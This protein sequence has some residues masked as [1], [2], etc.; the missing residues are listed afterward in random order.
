VKDFSEDVGELRGFLGGIRADGGGDGPEDWVGGARLVLRLSWG[1]RVRRIVM[2]LAD[3]PAHG[4]RWGGGGSH[5][6]EADLLVPLIEEL[7]A[8]EVRFAGVAI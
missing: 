4:A 2:W 6:E 1:R 3:A 8:K 5:E 7:Y